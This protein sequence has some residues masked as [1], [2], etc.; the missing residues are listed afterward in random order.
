MTELNTGYLIVVMLI[1]AAATFL[2]RVIPFIAL[3]NKAEHPI[4]MHLGKYLPPAVMTILVLY[5]LKAVDITAAPYGAPELTAVT[6][7]T[8]L[9][10][11][12]N[13]A[14]LSIFAGTGL[15]MHLV[16]VVIPT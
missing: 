1:M 5:S 3:R 11:W 13:N 6:A 9:H 2:T 4:L 15:Y 8:L 10:L 16:Q 12:R 7:T 14:L